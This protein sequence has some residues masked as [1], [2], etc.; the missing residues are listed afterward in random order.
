MKFMIQTVSGRI[1]HDFSFTLIE[2]IKYYNWKTNT[3]DMIWIESEIPILKKGFVPIGSNEFVSEYL[4]KMYGVIPKPK[5]VPEELFRFAYRTI[6]NG[7][8]KDVEFGK[9][10]KSNDKIKFFTYEIESKNL[11]IV[12]EGNYQISSVIKNLPSEWRGFVYNN[13]L[14]GIQNYAGDFRDFPVPEFFDNIIKDYKSAPVAYT[15][16]VA[17]DDGG[18]LYLIEIHDFFS[19]GLYGFADL[20]IL[21][22]MFYRWFNDFIIQNRPPERNRSETFV[23]DFLRRNRE[24]LFNPNKI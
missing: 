13:K 20:K 12:P 22:Y 16:D 1:V 2:A 15:I 9:F 21:P 4:Q 10:V 5:N 14:V 17:I 3:Q 11:D 18:L 24:E 6:K 23:D 8:K 19:C 7:T